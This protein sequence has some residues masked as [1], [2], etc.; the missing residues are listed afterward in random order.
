MAVSS[1]AELKQYALRAL[2]HPVV[3]VNVA[4]EQL[5]DRIDEALDYFR[6]YHYDGVE[7][8]FMKHQI[9][10]ST[11]EITTATANQFELNSTITGQISGATAVVTKQTDKSST[12]TTILIKNVTGTFVASETI[13]NGTVTATLAATNFFTLGDYDARYITTPDLVFGITRVLPLYGA[14]TSKNIFDVQY[15]LRLHDLYDLTSTSVIYYTQV[16]NHL[17]LLNEVLNGMPQIRFNRLQ[18]KLYL[19]V[20]WNSDMVLGDYIIVEGYRALDPNE[21]TKTWS[22][23]WLKHYTVALFK[24]QWGINLKKFGGLTLPGGVTLDGQGVYDEAVGEIKDLED[25]LMSKSSPLEFFT[26]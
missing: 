21:Y 7:K 17:T 18:N 10:A 22:E 6:L 20:N 23:P 4:D 24:R 19:D 16:R 14:S 1:R 11:L 2:G 25:D 8:I 26:G 15:Q 9:K 13:S 5:E 12:G 3:Q